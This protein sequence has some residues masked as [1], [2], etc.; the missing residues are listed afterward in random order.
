LIARFVSIP[1]SPS[2]SYGEYVKGVENPTKVCDDFWTCIL[3]TNKV[4][5]NLLSNN[6]VQIKKIE[7]K[8]IIIINVPEATHQQK[9]IY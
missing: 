5:Y 2:F 9:P 7:D 8:S 4:N 3:N 6:D 1:E